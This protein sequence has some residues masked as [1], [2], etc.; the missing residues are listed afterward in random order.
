[1]YN[2]IAIIILQSDFSE[3]GNLVVQLEQMCTESKCLENRCHKVREFAFYFCKR[4][5]LQF[6]QH[7]WI[8]KKFFNPSQL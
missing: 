2:N 8:I 3:H 7:K 6:D 1:M 4:F 5:N